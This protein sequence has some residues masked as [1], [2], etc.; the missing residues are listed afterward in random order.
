MFRLRLR[1]FPTRRFLLLLR[2]S[3]IDRQFLLCRRRRRLHHLLFLP[4]QTT[5]TR[6]MRMITIVTKATTLADP[7]TNTE[8][9]TDT[10]STLRARAYQ[11]LP[12]PPPVLPLEPLTTTIQNL[13]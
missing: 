2:L 10:V 12:P 7:M 1:T 5:E 3:G 11:L 4:T 8:T 6:R 13:T 9:E